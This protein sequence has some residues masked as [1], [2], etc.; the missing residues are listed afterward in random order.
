M[1]FYIADL[2]FGH[3]NV[4]AFDNR[5]F[6]TVEDNDESLIN[7]WNS[8]VGMEDDV[9]ILGD[10]SWHNSTETIKIFKRLNGNKHLIRGN[11]DPKVL[12]NPKLQELFVEITD[13]KEIT[14]DDG[15]GL[16][17]CHY[18]ILAFKNHYHNWIHLYGHVHNTWE[19]EL[20]EKT[21]KWSI[22]I[23]GKPCRMYNVG[24]MMPWMDYTPRTLTEI[25]EVCENN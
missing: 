3:R 22:E 16:V 19:Y 21:R 13:Y 23:S 17:L 1:N 18:P 15:K 11:H 14:F 2:H 20:I 6:F 9:Y 4:L 7:D 8:V 5:P 12:K 10:I 25:L 24:C